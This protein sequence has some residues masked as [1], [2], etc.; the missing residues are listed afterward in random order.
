MKKYLKNI[1]FYVL[2]F[3]IMLVV[4]VL[5]VQP[6]KEEPKYFSDLVQSIEQGNV[7]ELVIEEGQ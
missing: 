3:A 4:Y 7:E 2:L 5:I 6:P 1:S